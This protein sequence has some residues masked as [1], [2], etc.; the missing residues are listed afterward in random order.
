MSASW[1]NA[2]VRHGE[3]AAAAL[4]FV[5]EV[6]GAVGVGEWLR[7]QGQQPDHDGIAGRC[8]VLQVPWDSG[9]QWH[10][11]RTT[12]GGGAG[13]R[14][15]VT[16]DEALAALREDVA[17]TWT[18]WQD[19]VDECNPAALRVDGTHYVLGPEPASDSCY[20]DLLGCGGRRWEFVLADGRHVVSHNVWVQGHIPSEFREVLPDN[21]RLARFHGPAETRAAHSARKGYTFGSGCGQDEVV[22]ET[23]E[24]ERAERLGRAL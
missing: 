7:Y 10:T 12:H 17:C 24:A 22:E 4:K 14:G 15:Y 13:S 21:A 5:V 11:Y 1:Q 16:R 18:Y 20:R 3:P 2:I 19:I 8:V 6:G 9:T 23:T